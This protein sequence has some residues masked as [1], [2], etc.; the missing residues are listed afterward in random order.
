MIIMIH[1]ES[2]GSKSASVVDKYKWSDLPSSILH[3]NANEIDAA[4][5]K[6]E[7]ALVM[8]HNSGVFT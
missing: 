7:H 1:R 4:L 6:E 3:L 8:F 5:K 2:K